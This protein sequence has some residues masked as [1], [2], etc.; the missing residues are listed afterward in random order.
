[1]DAV[2]SATRAR[3]YSECRR[4]YYY[5]YYL[6]P[7][8]R[9]P[10][11]PPRALQAHQVKDLVGLEAW[12]GDLIHRLIES[13]LHR[14]RSGRWMRE[15]ELLELARRQL[16][17]GF[18]D[19]Q[20]YW[21]AHPDEYR[22]RPALLDFHYYGDG[23]VTP[24]RAARIKESV[25]AGLRGFVRS[26][27][28]DQIR[29]VGREGWLPIDRN[30]SARLP[31]GTLVLVKP[32]FAFRDGEYLHVVDWKTGKA[33]TYWEMVQV[34]CYALFAQEK[35]DV[36]LAQVVPRVV[37]LSPEFHESEVEFTP[38]TVREVLA[39]IHDSLAD[40]RSVDPAQAGEDAFPLT[41]ELGRCQ[42]CQFRGMCDGAS[43]C[44]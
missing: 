4:K 21:T 34:T 44:A 39:I 17:R 26:G 7:L 11:A 12:V 43:R 41:P 5:R 23:S 31:D 8:G 37:H 1:M 15:E 16:S 25:E 20:A 24:E 33:D 10:E 19:S 30:A 6:A 22:Y 2:W 42:W 3:T 36:S 40:L 18:R 28:A 29:R 35:W 32:D 14:G 9:G 38:R 13:Y 27:L